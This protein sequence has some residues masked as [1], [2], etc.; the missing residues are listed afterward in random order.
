MSSLE[1]K[2]DMEELI[3]SVV[4]DIESGAEVTLK[5]CGSSMEPSISEQTD[6]I[7]LRK[8]SSEKD[9]LEGEIY[10]YR[11]LSGR[12]A[13]HRVYKNNGD[14]LCMC[15]DAQFVLE[16][17]IP[18]E[19]LIAIVTQI[20]KPDKTVDCLDEGYISYHIRRM[21]RRQFRFRHKL[22]NRLCNLLTRIK[23][24][25]THLAGK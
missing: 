13:V 11:R 7:V 16:D 10:L 19:N 23:R 5:G 14:T 25:L 4:S 2:F 3:G 21:K 22:L 1:I 18:K 9:V 17:S 24:K 15:G 8:I 12:Y 6:S 20:I